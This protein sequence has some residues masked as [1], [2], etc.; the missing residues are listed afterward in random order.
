MTAIHRPRVVATRPPLAPRPAAEYDTSVPALVLKL[1]RYPLHAGGLGVIRTLARV[2]IPVVAVTEDRFTPL[3]V[4]RCLERRVIWPTT[5]TED[6]DELLA[7]LEVI[8]RSFARRPVLVATDDEAAVLV[9]RHAEL[10]GR[11][12]ALPPVE[13]QLPG[14]LADKGRLHELCCAVDVSSPASTVLRSRSEVDELARSWT[15]PLVLKNAAPFT[16]LRAPAVGCSTVVTTRDELLR[17][18][19]AWPEDPGL[20]VQEYLP[21]EQCDDWIFH[22]YFGRDGDLLVGF[23]GRKFRSWPPGSG[24]TTFAEVVRNDDLLELSE[25]LGQRVGYRG[26]ADLDWRYDGRDGHY[27]LLDFNPRV[28]AQFRLFEDD[29][30]IDVVR[31][32]HLDLTG[33]RVPAGAPVEGRRFVLEHLDACARLV[34]RPPWRPPERGRRTEGPLEL[35]FFSLRDPLPFAAMAG[36]FGVLGAR[37]LANCAFSRWKRDD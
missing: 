16:R 13:P 24:V 5:G 34:A 29:A 31:A 37:R 35:G 3:A 30:G 8:G 1:G 20:L 22:G 36:R 12:F 17:R 26:V 9:A 6:D 7:G 2:G 25:Y 18:A 21:E 23:T 15:F 10:L 28:G 19:D 11:H 27:K 14:I 4:S 33:R 32:L